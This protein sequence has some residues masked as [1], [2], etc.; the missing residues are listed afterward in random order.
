[1]CPEFGVAPDWEYTLRVKITLP[2]LLVATAFSSQ[3][4]FASDSEVSLGSTAPPMQVKS[5]YK[6]QPVKS[7]DKNKTYVVE[8]W[9]T[10][11]GPCK[12]SIPHLTEMAK[13]NKD[14][15]FVGVSIWEDDKEGNIKSF[16]DEMGSKMDYN[17]GYSGNKEGMASSWMQA[18]G[19]NGIP[20]AF[21][22]KGG[23][24]QWIGHPMS[25]EKPLADIKSGKY[26]LAGEKVKFDKSL[27]A[28]KAQREAFA[29]LTQA[30]N[31]Y[32]SGKKVEANAMLDEAAKLAPQAS[33]QVDMIRLQWLAKDDVSAWRKKIGELAS[34]KNQTDIMQVGSFAV[35][36]AGPDGDKAIGKEAIEMVL[37]ATNETDFVS[38]YYASIFYR[39]T[40]DT[41]EALRT[42]TKARDL[43]EKTQ[44]NSP[45]FKAELDK[46]I[47]ELTAQK[48]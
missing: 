16:V 30:K 20:T 44:Y 26:D 17:I 32:K 47:K 41:S 27:E 9:A 43:L 36:Q 46:Q 31:L 15:T 18:A 23:K 4:A 22:I 12:T 24:V 8:F 2:V 45:Q 7:F 14:V 1:M 11:C 48:K 37:K 35:G 21:V 19:Q 6:G 29:K 28:G 5:W 25:L 42:V 39:E 40:K 33:A 3:A 34:S 10:W 38:L 13:A